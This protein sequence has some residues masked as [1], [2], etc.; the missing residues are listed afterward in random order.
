MRTY[1]FSRIGDEAL[2]ECLYRCIREDILAGEL[3]PGE[4]LPSKRSFAK[5]LGVSV[6]TV[7]NAYEQ[8]CAEGY[9]Y[10]VPRKGFYVSDLP[11]N[12]YPKASPAKNRGKVPIVPEKKERK[13]IDFTSNQMISG[14]FPFSVWSK[15]LRECLQE[16]PEALMDPL[17]AGGAEVLKNAIA[18]HLRDFRGMQVE[19]QQ[20]IIGAG[21]E[22]LYSQIIQLLGTDRCY[23]VEDPGYHKIAQVYESYG[24]EC[25]YIRFVSDGIDIEDLERQKVEIAHISPSH[26]FP[27]GVVTPISKRYELLEWAGKQNG[28]YLIED[29]YDSEFRLTGQPIPALSSIDVHEKVIFMNTFS[30]SISPTVRVA[31]M[32]LPPHLVRLYHEKLAFCTCPVSNM[33]QYVLAKFISRG[34]FEKH[35]NRVRTYYRKQRD[36]LLE[37]IKSSKMSE[38][39]SIH[40]KDAGLHFLLELQIGCSDR[41]LKD[42]LVKRGVYVRPLSEYYRRPDG[43][44]AHSFVINYSSLDEEQIKRAVEIL[45]EETLRAIRLSGT[46]QPLK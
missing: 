41:E 25:R 20:I 18:R 14:R 15:L 11:E 2:Y 23:G 36:L 35:I 30:K 26:H 32:V 24:A 19:A 38:Y 8:L 3:A 13:G 6:I 40:E 28:R 27:T 21:T 45:E 7:E 37:E 22:Y 44:T 1:S 29:D 34:Y 42:R 46:G 10:S 31:Y 39:V 33:T 17:P 16:D 4:K 43:K 9:I 12:G 5:N